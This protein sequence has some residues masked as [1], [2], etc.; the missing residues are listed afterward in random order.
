MHVSVKV[1]AG[2]KR[3]KVVQ[4][5]PERFEISVREEAERNM[6]NKRVIALIALHFG[7]SEKKV[8]IVKGHRGP[9][10]LLS[11]STES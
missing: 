6:A 10:K 7:V 1:A 8:R 11:I 2:A 5:A 4:V 9:A 3:E